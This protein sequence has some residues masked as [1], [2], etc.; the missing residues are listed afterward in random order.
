SVVSVALTPD[1]KQLVTASN[2]KTVR[3]WDIETGKTVRMI[4]GEAAPGNWG[5]IYAMALSPDGRWLAV[6]G[7]LHDFD[8][9][10]AT[11]IRLYDFA[12][13]SQ[14]ALLKGQDDVVKALAFSPDGARLI[15]GGADKTAI[16]WDLAARKPLVRLSGHERPI[17][18]VAFT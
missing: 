4:R 6:G 8:K 17:D 10:I 9:S 3:V 7:Y 13:G 16:I 2:D 11:A 18:A 15:S 5:S 14:V 12:N 1:G